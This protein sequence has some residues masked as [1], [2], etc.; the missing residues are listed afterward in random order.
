MTTIKQGS[1]RYDVGCAEPSVI[2]VVLL[3]IGAGLA[4][5]VV[6]GAGVVFVINRLR[7]W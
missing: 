3:A 2:P 7:M 6:I 5:L 4:V 1:D